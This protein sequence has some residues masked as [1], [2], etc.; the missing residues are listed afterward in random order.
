MPL[1]GSFTLE[2]AE[3]HDRAVRVRVDSP[4]GS[5]GPVLITESEAEQLA[6]LVTEMFELLRKAQGRAQ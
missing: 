5:A 1:E 4:H 6:T 3:N 2:F